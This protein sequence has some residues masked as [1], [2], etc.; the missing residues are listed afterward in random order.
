MLRIQSANKTT[1][2]HIGFFMALPFWSNTIVRVEADQKLKR[3]E[4]GIRAR[5]YSCRAAFRL[6]STHKKKT[7][8]FSPCCCIRLLNRGLHQTLKLGLTATQAWMG[9]LARRFTHQ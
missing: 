6:R 9:T 1:S 5:V 3:S 2:V 8:G 4:T 7:L